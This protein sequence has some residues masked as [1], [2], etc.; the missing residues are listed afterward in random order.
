MQQ[1]DKPIT[2]CHTHIFTSDH[3]PPLLA[4][5]F[6]PWPFF[7]VLNLHWIIKIFKWRLKESRE[8]YYTKGKAKARRRYNFQMFIRRSILL[9]ILTGLIGII[10]GVYV[11]YFIW[12]FLGDRETTKGVGGAINWVS[13]TLKEFK[14]GLPFQSIWL[15]ILATAVFILL[16]KSGRNLLFFVLKNTIKLFG[17]LPGKKTKELIARYLNIA[18]FSI[19]DT[20]T[21]TFGQLCRQYPPDTKFIVLPM[22]MDFMDAGSPPKDYLQQMEELGKLKETGELGDQLLPFI[23]LDPRR[24][25]KDQTYFSYK[26]EDNK[27]VLEDCL[28]KTYLEKGFCGFKIYP[29]LGYYAFD[30]ALLPLW[31]FASD[32][33][34]PIMTHCIRGTIFYRGSKIKAWDNHPVFRENNQND[35]SRPFILLSQV[36]NIEF[37]ENFTHPLNYFCLLDKELLQTIIAGSTDKKLHTLFGYDAQQRTMSQDLKNLKICFGHFGGDDEW[38]RFFELDRDNYSTK[39]LQFPDHGIFFKTEDDGTTPKPGK[40]E[41][42]WKGADWYTIICSLMLQYPNVYADISY[43]VHDGAGVF[44]LLKLT[45]Q[46]PELRERVLYGTDFYVVRNHKSDKNIRADALSSLSTDEFNQIA[47]IN[48][49]GYLNNTYR[50]IMPITGDMNISGNE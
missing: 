46:N 28:I 20:Q 50:A 5:K 23:F 42:I 48:P 24:I 11:F 39:L 9:S 29:A 12:S 22:D 3:V 4:K 44:P 1:S 25:V 31:K 49:D 2:N 34:F 36:K 26:V 19:H 43:I 13:T 45:L 18:R 37:Q 33:G 6:V 41:Q 35:T 27:V 38:H 40:L 8:Q 32:N 14:I 17:T 7:H 16:F 30:E 47:R 10:L 21:K 15:N